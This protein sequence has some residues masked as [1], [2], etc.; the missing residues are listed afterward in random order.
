M[1]PID[2]LIE[3]LPKKKG[4]YTEV[5][6]IEKN[7]FD[8]VNETID[9]CHSALKKRKLGLNKKKIIKILGDNSLGIN[10]ATEIT[11]AL[12]QKVDKIITVE[13]KK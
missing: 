6:P 5:K 11:T 13:E 1:N 7:Y 8:G 10:W 12:S 2:K 4:R 9:A 3:E